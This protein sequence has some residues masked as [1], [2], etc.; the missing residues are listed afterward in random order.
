MQGDYRLLFGP[1]AAAILAGGIVGL[2]FAVP[3]YSQV[4]QTVSEIGEVGSPARIPFAALLCS[5]AAC[6]LVFAAAAREGSVAARR[7]TLPAYVTA[8]MAFSALGA[9][10]FAYPHPLHNVF[11][12]SELL[13]YQAPFVAALTWRRDLRLSRLV[14]FSWVMAWI[15]GLALVLNLSVLARHPMAWAYLKPA[16]GLVQRAL[17]AAW[18]GWCGGVGVYLFRASAGLQAPARS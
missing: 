5:V 2:A 11:G 7:S 4:R 6:L 15:V 13:G 8:A 18:F 16:Y 10:V 3:G 1:L 9:G 12:L 14:A 17:F